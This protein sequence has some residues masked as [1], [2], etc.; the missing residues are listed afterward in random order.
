VDVTVV[1]ACTADAEPRD[2]DA[3]GLIMRTATTQD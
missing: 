3:L 1:V 2:V